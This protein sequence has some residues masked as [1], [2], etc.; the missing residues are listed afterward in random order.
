MPV[1]AAEQETIPAASGAQC[2][3]ETPAAPE[4]VQHIPMS[5]PG[6][7][8]T[9]DGD[10]EQASIPGSPSAVA[11]LFGTGARTQPTA[12]AEQPASPNPEPRTRTEFVARLT[13]VEAALEQVQLYAAGAAQQTAATAV[14]VEAIAQKATV[15]TRERRAIANHID[16]RLVDLE[17]ASEW[18]REQVERIERAAEVR[19]NERQPREKQAMVHRRGISD[20][21]LITGE[22][23]GYSDWVFKVK[24]FV[25][26]EEGFERYV[27]ILENFANSP[28][29]GNIRAYGREHDVDSNWFDEQIFGILIHRA[30]ADSKAISLTKNCL[31]FLECRGARAWYEI[32]LECKVGKGQLRQDT[33]RD[34]AR[35]PPR[36]HEPGRRARQDPRLGVRTATV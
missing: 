19:T 5:P 27:E 7:G 15:E 8:T 34:G 22:A 12:K 31:D 24:A 33:L 2:P 16:R 23:P 20:I 25:R 3:A 17:R 36:N 30:A 35:S 18:V 28:S 6:V 13:Q 26:P 1:M 29:A 21:P 9:D 32:A 10:S 14:R 11:D 4:G